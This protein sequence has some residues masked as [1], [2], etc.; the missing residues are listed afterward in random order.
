VDRVQVDHLFR[1]E[2]L[3]HPEQV[4]HCVL[5]GRPFAAIELT[6]VTIIEIH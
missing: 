3:S 4:F 2:S 1:I 6:L 5:N